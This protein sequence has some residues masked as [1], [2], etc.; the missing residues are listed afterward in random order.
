MEVPSCLA[1]F[2]GLPEEGGTSSGLFFLG[3]A[4]SEGVSALE[5]L[6]EEAR[7]AGGSIHSLPS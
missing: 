5:L 2:G 6:E 7:I 4:T 1:S 3:D